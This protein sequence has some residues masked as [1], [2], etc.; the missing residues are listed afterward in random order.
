MEK[1]CRHSNAYIRKKAPL[2][3]IRVIRKVCHVLSPC[4]PLLVS[5]SLFLLT[6]HV[7]VPELIED[8]IP[9]AC[10]LLND[11]NHG[12]LLSAVTLITEMI[13]IDPE[14]LPQFRKVLCL[15]LTSTRLVSLCATNQLVPVL[16][17][18][19]KTKVLAGYVSDY[20]VCGITDPFLQVRIIH[21]LRLLGTGSAEASDEMNDIL[22][23]VC[24]SLSPPQTARLK[25][26]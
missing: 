11:K 10:Q 26:V 15:S 6:R 12:V 4:L 16:V 17:R 19:L 18:I 14:T 22:A 8:F 5:F 13:K 20:D 21:L 3:A 1:L 23:Q 24:L 2:C 25:I 9:A 7:Q